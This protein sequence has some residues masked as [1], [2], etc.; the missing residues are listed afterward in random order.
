MRPHS[1]L[2]GTTLIKVANPSGSKSSRPERVYMAEG[3]AMHNQVHRKIQC[4][5]GFAHPSGNHKI[6]TSRC[7]RR[8]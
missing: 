5:S 4:G 3:Q 6:A 7:I 2:N 1:V 8:I